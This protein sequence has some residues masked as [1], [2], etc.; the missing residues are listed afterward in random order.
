MPRLSL[1][2]RSSEK[3]KDGLISLAT[4][5]T[6]YKRLMP[7][8]FS[9]LAL[10]PLQRA[11]C[12]TRHTMMYH[13]E[14]IEKLVA[15]KQSR[16]E[17]IANLNAKRLA[18]RLEEEAF[19]T[20][21]AAEMKKARTQ[22]T[23]AVHQTYR[24][25]CAE[26]IEI[27]TGGAAMRIAYT[28]GSELPIEIW[29]MILVAV[30]KDIDVE[31][32]RGPSVIA[33]DLINASMASKELYSASLPAFQHLSSFCPPMPCGADELWNAFVSDPMAMRLED[34]KTLAKK[35]SVKVSQPRPALI[36]QLMNYMKLQRPSRI[37]A[38][39]L[40][41]VM[42]ERWDQFNT[43]SR[44]LWGKKDALNL[45]LPQPRNLFALRMQ[46][47]KK[48]LLSM[49]HLIRAGVITKAEIDG[50][51]LNQPRPCLMS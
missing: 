25:D 15:L 8:E 26:H 44:V 51:Q 12:Q 46:L 40:K 11:D 14:H 20:K 45:Q 10:K 50:I 2:K 5:E 31:G 29:E 48:G 38:K 7:Y 24:S 16:D 23:K 4:V 21:F 6:E 42:R 43:L 49:D 13:K 32:V 39:L 34:I 9:H 33:R 17:F 35:S 1:R 30:C 18:L 27:W 22:G 3:A 36:V 19:D 41:A 47:T 28:S 37:P